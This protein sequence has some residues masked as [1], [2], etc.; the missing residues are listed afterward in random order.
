LIS[1][2]S[3][4]MGLRSPPYAFTEQGVTMLSSVLGSERAVAFNI[5]I[6]RAVVKL[7]HV[8][9]EQKDSARNL[10]EVEEKVW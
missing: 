8:L 3:P 9:S 10:N 1:N 7:R 2:P 6:I 4:K 5:Q